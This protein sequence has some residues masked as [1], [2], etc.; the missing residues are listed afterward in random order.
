L[1]I[2]EQLNKHPSIAMGGAIVVIV[3]ALFLVFRTFKTQIKPLSEAYF[4][5]DDGKSFYS[6]SVTNIPPYDHN[7]KEGVYAMVFKD[8]HGKEVVLFMEKFSDPQKAQEETQTQGKGLHHAPSP[9]LI[10]KPG[11][12]TGG[13]KGDGWYNI[14]GGHDAAHVV[15]IMNPPELLS[16]G[17]QKVT[18]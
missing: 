16:G 17:W 14:I 18:P 11:E 3:V 8:P 4:T 9:D 13:P 1:G 15:G 12:D 2:R 6:D 10:K 5:D 7:G